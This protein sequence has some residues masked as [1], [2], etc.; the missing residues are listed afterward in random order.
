MKAKR[1]EYASAW[2]KSNSFTPGVRSNICTISDSGADAN[3][4]ASISPPSNATTAGVCGCSSSVSV[5]RSTPF[6]SSRRCINSGVPL[7]GAPMLT[8]QPGNCASVP[9]VALFSRRRAESSR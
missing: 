4:S 5:L 1:L 3:T 9:S 2:A 8:F 6:A 7:P